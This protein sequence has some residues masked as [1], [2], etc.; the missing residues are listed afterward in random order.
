MSQPDKHI[1]T[2][3][4]WSEF[5]SL[6]AARIALGRAGSSL[7]SRE[8]LRFA[9]AHAQAR[10]AVHT[11]LDDAELARQL[12]ADGHRVLLVHSAAVNRAEYLQR[13]DLGRRLDAV[14]RE[15]LLAETR[16][17]C[18]LLLV[19]AD[20]LSSR[21]AA[22]HARPLLMELLPRLKE[23]DLQIGPL[24]LAREARVALADEAG[25]CLEAKMTVM[26][27]GERP[28]LSSPDSLGLYLTG[29]PR[30]GRSD[31]ERN[32]ISNVRP[33]GLPYPLAAFKLA[34]LIAAARGAQT[35]I[36]LKDNSADDPG[37]AALLA[38]Q[39]RLAQR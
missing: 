18:D 12:Q 19:L 1:V 32:C 17:G 9:L 23:M 35:G 20:G 21:A 6:T 11:P 22:Q 27:I 25:E 16:K 13:P 10:D 36:A 37:W 26:L 24:L 15:R 30:V 29:A 4:G 7:P 3:D 31:A 34:W 33:D 38:R 2:E 39:A 28:G 14:S 8:T 5:S